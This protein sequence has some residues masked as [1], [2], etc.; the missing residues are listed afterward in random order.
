MRLL[1]PFALLLIAAAPT[2]DSRFDAVWR[3][4]WQWR[5]AE[6]LADEGPAK[7][8]AQLPD[9]SPAAHAKRTARWTQT[10]GALDT[11]DPATLSP[12][13]RENYLVYRQQ[14]A[15]LLDD[16]RFREWEKPVNGDSAFWSDLQGAARGS[17]A[18]GEPDY[19]AYLGQLGGHGR[20]IDGQIANLRA[21]LARG[22]TPPAIV[23]TGRDNPVAAIAEAT[24][25]TATVYWQPFAKLPASMPA[26]TRAAL[27]ADARRVI[28]DTVVPAHRR[29]LAFLR[30]RYF[31]GLRTRLD[32]S[33]YP[34]GAAY[35]QSRI[36]LYTTL[37]LTPAAIHAIGLAEVAKIRAEMA[38]VKADAKF[39][40]DL[41]AFLRFLRTDPRFYARTPDELLKEAAWHAKRF[42]ALAPRW[43]GR[44]PRQ[45]FAVVPVPPEIAPYYTAGRGGPGQYLVNTYDLP[46]R[47]LFQLPA[48]TLHESA[49]GHAF[50]I[51][52]AA[53][54]TALPAFRRNS[55][56]SAYGEGW[57]LYAERLGDE[58]GFYRDPY[59]RFGMLSYQMW[60]AV[61]LVVDT[62]IHAQGW[63][64]ERA[65]AFLRD[66]TALSAH[67]VTTEVDRYIG[68]PGQA[69][70]YYLGQL[71]IQRARARAQ[72]ALGA[73]FDI[74]AFHDT[75]LSLGSVP[76]PVLE[77]RV[78]R[79][80]VEGGKSPYPTQ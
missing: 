6:R 34:D 7:V 53:E 15:G 29:L 54:N 10:M 1:L 9:V 69:L 16:E 49:P 66:N 2:P 55:Y 51:P 74:R 61:R 26:T 11:I 39:S 48:L 44:M 19:R 73:R 68:W 58:M 65:Q 14:I 56:V 45:R 80:V 62:G 71:A 79:F 78:Q 31:P 42:D 75:V 22:F 43:F 33:S 17:F 36:R 3:A 52:L 8:D 37:D 50:Q 46:S 21:G 64:R 13:A 24:D 12:A 72:A 4:E 25:P 47:P 77:A 23:M 70:S 57:A 38:T 30:G 60:R 28:A 40:G 27:Q 41:P 63:S 67:E 20:Y 32:A 18:N 5:V 76:L 59:E 35:Y